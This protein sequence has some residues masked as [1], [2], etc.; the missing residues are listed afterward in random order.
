MWKLRHGALGSG[1]RLQVHAHHL[2]VQAVSLLTSLLLDQSLKSPISVL[3]A[4]TGQREDLKEADQGRAACQLTVP[5][6]PAAAKT[7]SAP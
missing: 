3:L 4:I 2:E 7:P 1:E 5:K 6:A